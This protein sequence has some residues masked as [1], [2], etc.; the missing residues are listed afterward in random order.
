MKK[1]FSFFSLLAVILLASCSKQPQGAS[2]V[3]DDATIVF[4][5]DI[6]KCA[7]LSGFGNGSSNLADKLKDQVSSMVDN[8]KLQSKLNDI[9][10]NPMKAGIDLSEP[11]FAYLRGNLD[12]N[13]HFALVGSVSSQ[14]KLASLINDLLEENGDDKL[15]EAD[16]AQ[17]FERDD[18]AFIFTS[19]WFYIGYADNARNMISELNDRASGSGSL[20][21]SKAMERLCDQDGMLQMLFLG[22][23]IA[24][25]PEYREVARLLPDGLKLRDIASILS[26]DMAKGE[27]TLVSEYVPLSKEWEDYTAKAA[28]ILKPIAKDQAKY[29]SDKGFSLF[30]N[31]DLTDAPK[32][33]DQ[34]AAMFQMDNEED[35]AQMKEIVSGL[36][37]T[38]SLDFFGINEEADVPLLTLYAGTK[39]TTTLDAILAEAVDND[40]VQQTG[41]HT[42]EMPFA[43]DY[44]FDEQTGEFI[45]TP[46]YYSSFGFK[47]GQTYFSLAPDQ[48]FKEPAAAYP[49]GSIKG[50]G[51][52]MRFNFGMLSA[53]ASQFGQ[54]EAIV[55]EVTRYFDYAEL[56]TEDGYRST[57]RL[58]T[59]DKDKTPMETVIALIEKNL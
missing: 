42:Y 31:I 55:D 51:L 41:E 48:L 36:D 19:D 43:Y 57:F 58:V 53:L 52:F 1:I 38:L 11:I 26:L 4:R 23:A 39:E 10:D 22:E 35:L 9:I 28:K 13:P 29:I 44:D 56:Y 49:A 30:L 3:P 59:K 24:S 5:A 17:Y 15:K 32:W 54:A 37:G 33:I 46:K 16:G 45:Q 8:K 25:I 27:A 21:G 18:I 50:K 34:L 47:Q 12:R 40:A 14:D 7:K 6:A 2:L 20:S